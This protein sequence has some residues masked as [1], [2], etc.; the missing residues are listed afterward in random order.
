MPRNGACMRAEGAV[1]MTAV[2]FSWDAHAVGNKH[3][4][5][6][7]ISLA[8]PPEPSRASGHIISR[9]PEPMTFL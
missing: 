4:E 3:P 5:H 9:P 8:R 7:V 6:Q 2:F 1:V